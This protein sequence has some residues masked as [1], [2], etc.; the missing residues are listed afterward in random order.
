MRTHLMTVVVCLLAGSSM[1]AAQPSVQGGIF[2]GP[3]STTLTAT[4]DEPVPDF[5]AKSGMAIGGYLVA[6]VAGVF[7]M[8]PEVL[9]SLRR[10][11]VAAGL[12]ESTFKLTSLE[13]PVLV[14]LA[15]VASGAGVHF[16]AGPSFNI[17][18]T[19]TQTTTGPGGTRK[20]D[21]GDQARRG[22][23]GF[24]VGGGVDVARLRLDARYAWG[25]SSLNT[26]TSENTHTKSRGFTF[27]AG[28]RLW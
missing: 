6:P 24:I 5:S 13:F 22:E 25:L 18:L 9:Y 26:D 7:A 20:E 14:R 1:A 17:R 11:S 12:S 28:L 8:E 15:P 4:S 10:A 21:A 3:G 19:A 23:F 27:L 16:V 2:G